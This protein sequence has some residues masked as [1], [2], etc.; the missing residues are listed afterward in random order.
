MS[1]SYPR[2]TIEPLAITVTVGGVIVT[3]GVLFALTTGG[4]R[5]TDWTAALVLDGGEI[6]VLISGLDPG[7]WIPFAMVGTVVI[8]CAPFE[9]T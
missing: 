4:N 6:G 9:V 7:T 8:E 1:N 3:A 5:P 2:E